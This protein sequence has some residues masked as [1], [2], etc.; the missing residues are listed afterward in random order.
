MNY[1]VKTCLGANRQAPVPLTSLETGVARNRDSCQTV[2]PTEGIH[3]DFLECV[4][5][6]RECC[7]KFVFT[8]TE[9]NRE[10]QSEVKVLS[11]LRV[12]GQEKVIELLL[13]F[14]LGT[15]A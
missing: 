7:F 14:H 10:L 2:C 6:S 15:V 8:L 3:S 11:E 9:D 12:T 1:V 13:Y 5:V 4:Q